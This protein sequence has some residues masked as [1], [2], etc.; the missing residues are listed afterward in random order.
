MGDL[1]PSPPSGEITRLIREWGAGQ[2]DSLDRLLQAVY[3]EL[4]RIAHR[5]CAKERPGHTLQSTAVVHEAYIRLIQAPQRN[6]KDRAHFFAFAARLMRGILVD[7]AR[8]RNAGKRGRGMPAISLTEAEGLTPPID[9]DL[10]DLEAALEKLEHLDPL[11]S[12][13]IELRF[14]GG[15]SL[16]ETA[17]V[18]A[19]S[20]STVTREWVVAKTWIRRKLLEGERK[21]VQGTPAS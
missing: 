13:I 11:Q 2:P 15:L 18:T 8:A 3:P 16:A 6:W 21:P 1:A 14:F 20:V 10:L 9:V 5:Y 17:E 12:R 7:Y 4:H 19:V